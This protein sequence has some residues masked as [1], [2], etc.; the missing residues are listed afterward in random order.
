[1]TKPKTYTVAQLKRMEA[2]LFRTYQ[3]Y[4]KARGALDPV[5]TEMR[6]CVV[7]NRKTGKLYTTGA[8]WDGWHTLTLYPCD[9]EMAR[10]PGGWRANP[11]EVELVRL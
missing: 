9:K 4:Q 1:M 7:R 6:G 2:T 10:E 3:A 8:S 11:S 5:V